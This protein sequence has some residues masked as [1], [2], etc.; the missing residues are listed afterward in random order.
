MVTENLILHST[1]SVGSTQFQY[2]LIMHMGNKM[3]HH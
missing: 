3:K 1:K 2:T